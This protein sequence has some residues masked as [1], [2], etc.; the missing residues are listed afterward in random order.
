MPGWAF[1]IWPLA[2]YVVRPSDAL[3]K[4]KAPPKTKVPG[5]ATKDCP[6][7]ASLMVSSKRENVCESVPAAS[8]R[9]AKKM[10]TA[11]ISRT[12]VNT[13]PVAVLAK[14]KNTP[15]FNEKSASEQ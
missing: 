9:P 4:T 3:P 14:A 2:Q 11:R 6:A 10:T 15:K 5:G 12:R 1:F 13:A 8:S 7:N